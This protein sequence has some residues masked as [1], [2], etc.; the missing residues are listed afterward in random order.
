MIVEEIRNIKSA[1]KDLRQFGI[2]IAVVLGLL[3]GWLLWRDRDGSSLVLIAAA[4]FLFLGC[5]LPQLLK[6]FHKLWMTLAVLLGW[7]MTR[8]ILIILFFLVV[9]PIGLL[10]RLFGKD[11]LNRKFERKA[12]SYWIPRKTAVSEKKDYERQF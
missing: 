3:G 1:K 8:V 10:A 6:P 12:T 4:V 7:L 11:F 2:T 5:A 9:T